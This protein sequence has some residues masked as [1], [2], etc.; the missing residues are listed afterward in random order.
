MTPGRKILNL[1][2]DAGIKQQELAKMAGVSPAAISKIETYEHE[3]NPRANV[4][5]AIARA[6]WV[7]AD[8]LLDEEAPYPPPVGEDPPTVE[9]PREMVEMRVTLEERAVTAR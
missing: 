6:L 7:T 2:L 5:H 8:Y 3:R 1:R 4:L 9:R